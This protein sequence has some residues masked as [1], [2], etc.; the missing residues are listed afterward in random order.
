MVDHGGD[1]ATE[2]QRI[3]GDAELAQR[4]PKIEVDAFAH[5]G[6]AL[7]LED[8]GHGEVDR[9]PGRWQATPRSGVGSREHTLDENPVAGIDGSSR[10]E[11]EV[12]E[13]PMVLQ[14]EGLDSASSVVNLVG[15]NDLVAGSTE[16]GDAAGEVVLVLET[17]VLTDKRHPALPEV[18]V[19]GHG[20]DRTSGR[21]DIVGPP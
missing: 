12:R 5:E 8:H 14:E 13:G 17:H 11:P 4:G 9:P 1:S 6:I 2:T 15:G 7:E 18:V 19:E 21:V 20:G 10:L 3:P 16:D